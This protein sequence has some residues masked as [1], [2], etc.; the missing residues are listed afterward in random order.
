MTK[1]QRTIMLA[2]ALLLAATA[3]LGFKAGQ[4]RA[5]PT[6]VAVVNLFELMRNLDELKEHDAKIAT[7]Q[8]NYQ[9]EIDA[10]VAELERR[11]KEFQSLAMTPEEEIQ[12]GGELTELRL[13]VEAAR[14]RSELI[15][16]FNENMLM[17]ELYNKVR[18]SAES[19]ANELG[20]DMV[21][22]RSDTTGFGALPADAQSGQL[23]N[24][25]LLRQIIYVSDA[26]DIT[27][28]LRLRMNNEYN[29]A[30]QP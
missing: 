23:Q 1:P 4:R 18:E 16:Q 5:A 6:S 17:I 2:G 8:A 27:E 26:L 24:E 21:L 12:R 11:R 14:R 7:M 22:V 13:N 3:M 9:A 10:A 20:Y 29:N 19:L 28:Q 25:M 30:L 15:L